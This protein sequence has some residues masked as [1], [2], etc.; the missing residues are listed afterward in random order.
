MFCRL[1][2]YLGDHAPPFGGG[3]GGGASIWECW[4]S[5]L[6]VLGQSSAAV[7]LP[8]PLKLHSDPTVY[9]SASEVVWHRILLSGDVGN[10]VV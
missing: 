6:G 1:W 10:P 8:S 2:G 7:L 9:L 3:D 4:A 5:H